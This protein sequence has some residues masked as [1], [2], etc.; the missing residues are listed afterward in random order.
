MTRLIWSWTPS[1]IS[2]LITS[3][4]ASEKNITGTYNCTEFICTSLG[5]AA[6]A[7]RSGRE[8]PNRA[9][10]VWRSQPAEPGG[11]PTGPTRKTLPGGREA[12]ETP[13]RRHPARQPAARG[14]E[15]GMAGQGRALAPGLGNVTRS[16][17][18]ESPGEVAGSARRDGSA[19]SVARSPAHS[20]W[21][22]NSVVRGA[23]TGAAAAAAWPGRP[24]AARLGPPNGSLI[25][26]LLVF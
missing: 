23:L 14:D 2:A 15:R 6:A 21:H 1:T 25:G 22:G 20:G 8:E 11:V 26:L 19:E 5:E 10:R 3:R 17:F 9:H 12:R 24:L 18:G 13:S 4:R 16:T 7:D